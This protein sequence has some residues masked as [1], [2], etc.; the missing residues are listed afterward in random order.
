MRQLS[1]G[2]LQAVGHIARDVSKSGSVPNEL[3]SQ[4][5]ILRRIDPARNM[6][7]FYSLEVERDL[8]G[9]VVLVRR[10]GRIGS[11]GKVRL[12]AHA[13]EGEALAALQALNVAK[14]KKG[15]QPLA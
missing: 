11:A 5:V 9:N 13:G 14:A 15:Y 4:S 10:W 6:N 3:K 1:F 8:L 7:R 2:F 12:D